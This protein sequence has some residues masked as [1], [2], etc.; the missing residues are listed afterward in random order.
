M[1]KAIIFIGKP[2]SGKGTQCTMLS[3]YIKAEHIT[4]GGLLRKEIDNNTDLGK[5]IKS[6]MDNGELQSN[7]IVMSILE[8]YLNN[9][10]NDIILDGVPRN[11]AQASILNN[12]LNKFQY[13]ISNVILLQ[14]SDILCLERILNRYICNSC[15]TIYSYNIDIC[16]KCNGNITQRT[17]DTREVALK[18][19]NSSIIF[20]ANINKIYDHNIISYINGEQEENKVFQDILQC[21]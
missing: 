16:T 5:K 1:K 20:C 19:I 11:E 9:I 21:L 14:V 17:D 13:V 12:I 2:G 10:E 18:R 3:Q 4:L 6:S 8:R 7:E 15:E